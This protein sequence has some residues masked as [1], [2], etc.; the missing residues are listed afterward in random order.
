M[1]DR[2]YHL[3]PDVVRVHDVERG[4]PLRDLLRVLG[5]EVDGLEDEI[6]RMY[7]D[8]FIETCEP[9]VVPYLGDLVGY[10]WLPV[11]AGRPSCDDEREPFASVPRRAVAD[12]VRHRRRKGTR[13]VV[14]DL[15]LAVSGWP[16]TVCDG[17]GDGDGGPRCAGALPDHVTVRAW[18]LPSWPLTQVR[19][20]LLPRRTNTFA[21]AVL[22]ND[23]PLYRSTDRG[24]DDDGTEPDPSSV[25]SGEP[26]LPEPL[27][28][29]LLQDPAELAAAY[30]QDRSLCL[31][32]DGRPV[33]V[34][35]LVVQSLGGWQ[36][37]VFG[38][39]VALDP[40]RGRV[41]FPERYR[42]PRVTASYHHGFPMAIGGGEYTRPVRGVPVTASLVGEGHLTDVPGLLD[43]L[44]SWEDPV[45]TFLRGV[46]DPAV[47]GGRPT[48]AELRAELNR[49]L[50]A[51]DF[52][53]ADVD[54]DALDDEGRALLLTAP[55]GAARIRLNRLVLEA[56]YPDHVARSYAR[57]RVTSAGRRVVMTAIRTSQRSTRPPLHLVVELADSGLYVEPVVVDLPA[58][59]TLEVRAAQ[60][61]R[62]TIVLPERRSDIDDMVVTC[63]SG[64]R[65]VLD[66]LMVSDHAVRVIGYPAEVVV[67]HCTLVPGWRLD[68]ACEPCCGEEPSLVITDV[69]LDDGDRPGR[70]RRRVPAPQAPGDRT[71]CVTVE[72]S[73]VGTI[74][75]QR[76]EVAADPVDLR[77]VASVVDS[78]TANRVAITAPN[79]RHAHAV[80]TISES[81]IIGRTLLHAIELGENAIFTAEVHVARR[82]VG[83]LRYCSVPSGSRTPRRHACQ[84]D[85]ALAAAGQGPGDPEEDRVRPVLMTARYGRPDY[86]RL[87]DACAA[88]IREGAD[89]GS[90]MGVHHDLHEPRR[91]ANLTTALGEYLPL[92][93]GLDVGFES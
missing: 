28:I 44:R 47:L 32:E 3:L 19:P 60:G 50:Q 8:L 75:V 53:A 4:Y 29:D 68:P 81:T 37:E 49:V 7:A 93:W 80:A 15:V 67:R 58:H 72:R 24:P 46:V 78:T 70:P 82:Q 89:D 87:D 85:L 10:R 13:S 30:G 57:V 20:Y 26:L 92:G 5:A 21:L 16:A 64:S 36:P 22:G 55:A 43:V 34:D 66:G 73:I 1:S 84:P 48:E 42:L 62:P 25:T 9:W 86:C 27:T 14:D 38:D 33:A 88:E 71:T 23:A 59:H 83:C 74:V 11:P 61:C 69:P 2:L 91:V 40:E 12:T 45:T 17:D 63:G 6:R 52:A 54:P 18:R 31:Y 35:R 79:D 41:M 51:Y 56:R 77:V 90:A 39:R 76:D 65:V